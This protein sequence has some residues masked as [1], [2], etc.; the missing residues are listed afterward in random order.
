MQ[1]SAIIVI[2]NKR[3]FTTS[4]EFANGDH[5][6]LRRLP[7]GCVEILGQSVLERT[8]EFLQHAGIQAIS[9]VA[10][11]NSVPSPR[12]RNVE[13]TFVGQA[14]DH[15]QTATHKLM[16]HA[17]W[18][19]EDVV[20]IELGAYAEC[21]FADALRFHRS[22]RSRLTQLQDS[23]Q[24][25]DVWI[26][27]A[28]AIRASA[29]PSGFPC[30]HKTLGQPVLLPIEG[31]V[32]RLT[33]ARDLRRLVVDAFLRRC[34]IRPRGR[35]IRPGVW[36]D[37]GARPH[38]SARIVAPAYLGRC[39]KLG[40][41][42]VI[43]RFSNVESNCHVGADT[44]VDSASILAH[45]ALGRG[46][47]VSHAVVHGNEFV[48]LGRNLAIRIDDP[49]LIRDTAPRPWRVFQSRHEPGRLLESKNKPLELEEGLQG[50]A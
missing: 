14:T 16:D 45:T 21:D 5:S 19:S 32:N 38:R 48:D 35:E 46:L 20:V 47:D 3:G 33:D 26:V 29:N 37:D 30:V 23:R 8:I 9:V 17:R 4:C 42:A 39:A 13:V 7:S 2:G 1:A 44:L 11:V 18:G 50:E 28:A 24:P 43:A 25:L 31:Y 6:T 36:M 12:A 34:A 40:R 49:K 15:W 27:N 22:K 10:G 41:S